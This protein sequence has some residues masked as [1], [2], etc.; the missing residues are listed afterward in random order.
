MH[1]S[2]DACRSAGHSSGAVLTL[3]AGCHRAPKSTARTD[4]EVQGREI[5]RYDTF[6]NE[7]F[8]TDS[9]RLVE[10]VDKRI[11]PSE[12]LRLGLKVDMESSTSASSSS[13]IRSA[14]AARRTC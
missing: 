1:P 2:H 13:A 7:Q 8:W 14:P 10:L 3:V 11:E 5:F 6:G 4:L 12:A 9:A